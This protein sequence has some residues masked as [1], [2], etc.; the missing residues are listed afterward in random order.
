MDGWLIA[1]DEYKNLKR[2][3]KESKI[4]KGNQV[5]KLN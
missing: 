1:K 2:N 4:R 3:E 5:I